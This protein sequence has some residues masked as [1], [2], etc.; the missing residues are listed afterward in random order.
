MKTNVSF[1]QLELFIAVA[2]ELN[3]GRAASRLN[4]SQPP[5]TRQI[6]S[7]EAEL[8]VL[9]FKRTKRTV[10]MTE[11]G[12][13]LLRDAREIFRQ[14][15]AAAGNVKSA[16]SGEEG[17]LSVAFEGAAMYDLIPRSV[18]MYQEKYPKVIVTMHDMTSSEQ[19]SA[20][21]Q[22]RIAVGFVSGRIKDRKFVVETVLKEPVTLAL[23]AHHRLA[24]QKIVPLKSIAAENLLLCPRAHNP[25]MYD[26]IIGMCRRAGFAPNIVHQPAEMQLVLGFIAS[27]L[28]IAVVPA[29]VRN[30]RRAGVVYRQMRPAGPQTELSLVWLKTN[31]SVLAAR[32]VEIVKTAA[33]D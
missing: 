6:Q 11:A 10:E 14:L 19:T 27:G 22:N 9:L 1:R 17:H 31:E 3:F 4:I 21:V 33:D 16:A 18:K 25:A 30:V 2:E 15:E 29:A 8:G 24:E 28:G 20:L 23:P 26:Q 13:V 7:L 12:T 5:L 32:F